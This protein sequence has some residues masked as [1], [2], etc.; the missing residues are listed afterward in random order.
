M[1]PH[2]M[3]GWHAEVTEVMSEICSSLVPVLL[4]IQSFLN[5]FFGFLSFLGFTGTPDIVTPISL[6]FGC[7]IS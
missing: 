4:S 2:T 1:P 3:Y 6:L 5:D 7:T